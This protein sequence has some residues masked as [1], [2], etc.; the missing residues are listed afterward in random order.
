MHGNHLTNQRGENSVEH[1]QKL[2]RPVEP[3]YEITH[4]IWAQCNQQL[5]A[6]AWKLQKSVTD[7]WKYRWTRP[8]LCPNPTLL[9][10]DKN[11]LI[12][13]VPLWLYLSSLSM[14]SWLTIGM[15][16]NCMEADLWGTLLVILIKLEVQAENASFEQS[17]T[18]HSK[19]SISM[20]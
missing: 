16:R 12:T 7:K 18:E 20:G 10:G 5:S 15:K 13:R 14:C 1:Y 11:C 9:M 17:T 6:N 3:H 2:I 4:Q 8:F 19:G